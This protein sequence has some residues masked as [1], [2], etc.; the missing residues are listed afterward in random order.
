MKADR[1]PTN[2][3]HHAH[4]PQTMNSR[5]QKPTSAQVSRLALVAVNSVL[6]SAGKTNQRSGQQTV[7]FNPYLSLGRLSAA[8]K[9]L[10]SLDGISKLSAAGTRISRWSSLPC[11]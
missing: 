11:A 7:A 10:P 2:G 3:A 6:L 9:I 1:I 5:L 4:T 8:R